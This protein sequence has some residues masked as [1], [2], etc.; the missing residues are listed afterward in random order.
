V[1]ERGEKEA[2]KLYT[3]WFHACGNWQIEFFATFPDYYIIHGCA[4]VV[5]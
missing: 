1:H 4:N 5:L 3:Y 2:K